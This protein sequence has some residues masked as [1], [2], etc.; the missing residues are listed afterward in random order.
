MTMSRQLNALV[1]LFLPVLLPPGPCLAQQKKGAP[2]KSTA[3]TFVT[4]APFTFDQVFRFIQENVIPPRRQKEAI[5]NRG[6]DFAPTPDLLEKLRAAGASDDMIEL[7]SWRGKPLPPK[8]VKPAPPKTGGVDITC[9]PPECDVSIGG[10]SKGGTGN[11]TLHVAGIPPGSA[12]V[13]LKRAGYV[14]A[15]S[16]VMIEAGKVASL[17]VTLEPDRE[18]KEAFGEQL[19]KKMVQARRPSGPGTAVMPAGTYSF[20]TSRTARCFKPPAPGVCSTKW[21][22]PAASSNR[23]RT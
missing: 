12:A 19:F 6:V 11:G 21:P 23:A 1:L 14:E 9:A 8:V 5:Q 22:L 17:S 7:I 15:Q 13:D 16:T 4:G 20:A 10:V 18:T 3:D 2:K